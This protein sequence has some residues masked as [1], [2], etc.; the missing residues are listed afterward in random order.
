MFFSL[1]L[2]SVTPCMLNYTSG[3]A[4]LRDCLRLARIKII[5]TS[6]KFVEKADLNQQIND[7]NVDYHIIYLE[8]LS[9]KVNS[10]LKI[11]SFFNFI[12]LM[13]APKFTTENTTT[14]EACILFTTGSEGAPKGVPLTQSNLIANYCQTQHMLE[15]QTKDKVLNVLPFFIP[16][17]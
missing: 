13:V 5:I 15:N 2:L 1:Q 11:E 10:F 14:Q 7:L 4:K 6:E 8:E 9:K 17:D 3:L 16:L 12:K